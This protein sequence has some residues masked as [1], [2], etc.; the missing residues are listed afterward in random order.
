M[1]TCSAAGGEEKMPAWFQPIAAIK[2]PIIEARDSTIAEVVD[3]V[4]QCI[5]ALDSQPGGISILT[6]GIHGCVNKSDYVAK[7]VSVSQVFRDLATLY[8]VEFHLTDVG[9]VVTPVGK[10]PFPNAKAHEGKVYAVYRGKTKAG[11]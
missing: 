4:S 6:E 5:A 2:I 8:Q 10:K 1:R 3:L 11:S 9:V 7:D